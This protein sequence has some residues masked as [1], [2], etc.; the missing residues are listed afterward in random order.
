MGEREHARLPSL[1]EDLVAA[2]DDHRAEAVH[3]AHV[4][5][6]IHSGRVQPVGLPR[7]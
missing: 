7:C 5:H 1:V 6:A 4:V 2:L 3:A